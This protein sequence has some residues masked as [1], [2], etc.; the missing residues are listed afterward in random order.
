MEVQLAMVRPTHAWDR[1][2]RERERQKKKGGLYICHSLE[3]EAR[4]RVYLHSRE[5]PCMHARVVVFYGQPGPFI[6]YWHT[7]HGHAHDQMEHG[8]DGSRI[9]A[10]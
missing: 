3:L 2:Q 4:R 1:A 6:P 10:A 9:T 5:A 7:H 8:G